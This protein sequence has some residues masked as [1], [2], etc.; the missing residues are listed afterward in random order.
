LVFERQGAAAGRVLLSELTRWYVVAAVPLV[1]AL[2]LTAEPLLG[3]LVGAGY[4][5]GHPVVVWA[6]LGCFLLGLQQRYQLALGLVQ[7]TRGVLV[8]AVAALILNLGLN[9]LL[10]PAYGYMAA[11][12]TTVASYALFLAWTVALERPHG[13]VRL[14][15]GTLARVIVAA[16]AMRVGAGL[17]EVGPGL[18][19]LLVRGA[20]AAGLYAG[21]LMVLGEFSRARRISLLGQASPARGVRG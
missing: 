9:F 16:L 4:A 14:S 5:D 15:S 1:V 12:A 3:F 17:L 18:G 11:A 19:P 10:V 7:R 8:A 2:Q 6:A 20:L 13:L 21:V